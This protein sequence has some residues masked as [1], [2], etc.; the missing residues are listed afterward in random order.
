M[1]ARIYPSPEAFKQALEQRLRTS[2]SSGA[3]FVRQRQV[4]VFERFLARVVAELGASA[5]LKGGL[6]LELRLKR[7]RTTN[8]VDLRFSGSTDTLLARLQT[9]GRLDLGEF[10]RFEVNLDPTHPAIRGDGMRYDGVRFQVV[11]RLAEK[12]YGYPFGLDVATADPMIAPPDLI[13]ASDALAFAGIAPP[14][15]QIYPVTTHIAEKLHAYSLPR[16]RPNTRVKD[17]PDLAL[18]GT[19][20]AID[21]VQLRAALEQTFS[22]RQTHALPLSFSQPPEAWTTPYATL[23]FEEQLGWP[24]L[25]AVAMAVGAFLDPVLAGPLSATWDPGSWRWIP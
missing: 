15:V 21:A 9:A 22:Y 1:T 8:D 6:V 2:T 16:Q 10:M 12:P 18:L 19:I 7:A 4:L 3:A 5:V 23:A 17:L 20:P 25:D 14:I 24:T 11:C 13:A